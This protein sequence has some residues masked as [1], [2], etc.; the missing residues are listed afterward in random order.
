MMDKLALFTEKF[1]V[2]VHSMILDK[3]IEVSVIAI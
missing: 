2:R 3:N 1:K